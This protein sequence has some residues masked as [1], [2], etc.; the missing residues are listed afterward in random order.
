MRPRAT[1]IILGAV[2]VI[3]LFAGLDAL[4]SAG[5]EPTLSKTSP[6]GAT[7]TRNGA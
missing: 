3:V 1:W 7:E 5:D 2:A 4:R 6:T